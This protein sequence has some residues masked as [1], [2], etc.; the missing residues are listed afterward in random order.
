M[1]KN[2]GR[3]SGVGF[4]A[5]GAAAG[6]L[7][8]SKPKTR[9][10]KGTGGRPSP[11]TTKSG[12]TVVP[13]PSRSIGDAPY[14]A[15]TSE[16]EYTSAVHGRSGGIR[17]AS[18]QVSRYLKML[19]DP[20]Q[21]QNGVRYPDETLT[22]TAMVHLTT[23]QTYTVPAGAT[24]VTSALQGK[25]LDVATNPTAAPIVQPSANTLPSA[26]PLLDY[27]LPQTTW[28]G[29]DAE[30]RTLAA[31]IRMRVLGNPPST[32][33]TTGTAYC[34][35]LMDD[36]A[37][38][39]IYN[40]SGVATEAACIQAVQS[41]KGFQ[42]TLDEVYRRGGVS[43]PLLPCGPNSFAFS[44]SNAAASATDFAHPPTSGIISK[45]PTAAIFIFGTVAGTVLRFDYAHHIEYIP[46]PAGAGLLQVGRVASSA[47]ARE[48]I[49][50]RVQDMFGKMISDLPS[51]VGNAA[52]TA[53]PYLLF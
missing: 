17:G 11:P 12:F 44:D 33:L 28:R 27:G 2:G 21:K 43:C 14:V 1:K 18:D 30:D 19:V 39:L 45:L 51:T 50:N 4:G 22:P 3:K 31:G 37:R 42:M 25:V 23:S 20:Y 38:A 16:A 10:A 35:Q 36:E 6:L 53:L 9:K 8:K 48:T 29:V 41:G 52:L 24:I 34:L 49:T 7:A 32:F 40:V 26:L 46:T 13:G 5:V 15:S 47:K